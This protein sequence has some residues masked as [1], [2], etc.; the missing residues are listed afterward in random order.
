MNRMAATTRTHPPNPV[1]SLKAAI[2]G[3]VIALFNDRRRGEAPVQRRTDGMFGPKAVAWRV[4]GGLPTSLPATAVKTPTL[5]V[6]A[7]IGF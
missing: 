2:T 7:G 3:Q 4:H 1:Q 5:M 6:L